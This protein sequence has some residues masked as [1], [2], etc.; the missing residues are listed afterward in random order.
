MRVE[1]FIWLE[2]VVEKL[3]VK[4]HVTVDE[5]EEV[6]EDR[7]KFL[8]KEK[9]RVIGEDLYN[10]LGQ[11]NSGRYLSIFFISKIDKRALII[12]A[13]DMDRKERN[14]YAKK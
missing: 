10:A 4:H 14:R 7:P 9:G 12:S 3:W 1:G 6:F 2:W 5:V 8:R 13:R 11:T